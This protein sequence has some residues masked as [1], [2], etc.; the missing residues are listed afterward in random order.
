MRKALHVAL[1]VGLQA[2]VLLYK[3][4]LL[5]GASATTTADPAG[6]GENPNRGIS[7]EGDHVIGRNPATGEIEHPGHRNDNRGLPN[8]P[9]SVDSNRLSDGVSSI[10]PWTSTGPSFPLYKGSDVFDAEVRKDHEKATRVS[11][12]EQGVAQSGAGSYERAQ[13]RLASLVTASGGLNALGDNIPFNV[14]SGEW[15]GATPSSGSLPTKSFPVHAANRWNPSNFAIQPGERYK[16]EVSGS[17]SDL[18]GA[19]TVDT[20]GYDSKWN[21]AKKCYTS[22][23]QCYPHLR[24]K[25]R[26]KASNWMHLIC[27]VGTYANLLIDAAEGVDR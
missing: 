15:T 16:I 14:T 13:A 10:S 25:L 8:L 6:G 3:P 27:G 18:Y 9:F 26:Y 19:K 24:Q 7:A 23:N 5:V 11:R 12:I 1:A 4:G 20:L 21:V 17:W 22:G 2:T